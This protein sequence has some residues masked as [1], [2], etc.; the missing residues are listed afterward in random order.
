LFNCV[1]VHFFQRIT[2]WLASNFKKDEG[3]DLLKDKQ[4]LQRLTEAAEKAKME[5]STLTQTNI[6]QAS[7]QFCI[8]RCS[9]SIFSFAQ[10]F[11][12]IF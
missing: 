3:I 5:L 7:F 8:Q 9:T 1:I 2:D 12:H 6:R 11:I 10:L 4:A